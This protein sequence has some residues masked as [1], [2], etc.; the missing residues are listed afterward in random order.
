ML[1]FHRKCA[2]AFPFHAEKGIPRIFTGNCL[3]LEHLTFAFCHG[4]ENRNTTATRHVDESVQ[5]KARQT[6]DEETENLSTQAQAKFDKFKILHTMIKIALLSYTPQRYLGHASFEAQEDSR[7]IIDFKSGRK[8]ATKWASRLFCKA[9][10][11]MDLKDTVIVCIPASC[12]RTYTRRFRKFSETL[13]A[14]TGA[15]NGF[16]HIKVIGKR[17]KCHICGEHVAEDNVWIDADFFKGKR[18][19]IIDDIC[20]TGRTSDEFREKMEQAGAH[21][22]MAMFLAKTT[23]FKKKQY[24][25]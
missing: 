12:Q 16:D 15:I 4:T 17:E 9:L 19:L 23:Q 11:L 14:K 5:K 18:I 25:N 7:H 24:F 20:T 21:V 13:C 2:A 10:S 3:S 1:Y 8:F 6:G 22:R